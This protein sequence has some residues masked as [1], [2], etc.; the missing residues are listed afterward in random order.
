MVEKNALTF[1]L[2]ITANMGDP[3]VVND[4]DDLVKYLAEEDFDFG[5]E[6]DLCDYNIFPLTVEKDGRIT[7]GD[8]I[9]GH[10]IK[11]QASY[12]FKV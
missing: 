9:L 11:F 7:Q 3:Y 2:I 1:P 6:T 8:E 12:S 5:G 10:K 4:A